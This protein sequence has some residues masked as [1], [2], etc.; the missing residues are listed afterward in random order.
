MKISLKVTKPEKFKRWLCAS[1]GKLQ[2]IIHHNGTL[3]VKHKDLVCWV[4]GECKIVCRFC[5]AMN[6][7]KTIIKLDDALDS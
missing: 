2:G 5:G 4:V 1:C 3:C 7:Y 6:E